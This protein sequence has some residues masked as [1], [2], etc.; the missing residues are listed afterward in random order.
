MCTIKLKKIITLLCYKKLLIAGRY[1]LNSV[2][3]RV[4]IVSFKIYSDKS[5]MMNF[6]PVLISAKNNQIYLFSKL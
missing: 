4:I 2:L 5:V 1:L 3:V 6:V